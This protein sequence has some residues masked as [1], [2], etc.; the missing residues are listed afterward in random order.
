[1]GGILA[2]PGFPR[3][4]L[5]LGPIRRRGRRGLLPIRGDGIEID[6]PLFCDGSE[7]GPDEQALEI[8]GGPTD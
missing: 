1:L 6:S 2:K 7:I 3:Q 8:E 5:K 4:T